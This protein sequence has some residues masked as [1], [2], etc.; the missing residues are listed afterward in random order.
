MLRAASVC[1]QLVEPIDIANW[2][3]LKNNL[4]K[5]EEGRLKGDYS[6]EFRYR[7]NI[8]SHIEK[9]MPREERN[10]WHT[11]L[12]RIAKECRAEVGAQRPPLPVAGNV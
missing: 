1:V 2:Y 9:H 7:P 10:A 6:P 5:N 3:R 11:Q 8:Y 4:E 12:L